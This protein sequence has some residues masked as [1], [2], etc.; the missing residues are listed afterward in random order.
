MWFFGVATLSIRSLG[1]W[2]VAERYIRQTLPAE[3]IWKRRFVILEQRLGILQPVRL[4]VTARAQVPAVVGWLRPI[5]LMPAS[6]LIGLTPEQ[7]EALLAHE[8]AHVRRHDFLVNLLQTAAETLF[9]Y[10]PAVWWL[11]RVIRNE[12]ENCCDDLAVQACGNVLTYARA[13]AEVE[14]LLG[15]APSLA[16]A[17]GGGSLLARIQRLLGKNAG[18]Q[19]VSSTSF[20]LVLTIAVFAMFLMNIAGAGLAQHSQLPAPQRPADSTVTAT[21]PVKEQT[22]S[23]S[24]LDEIEAAGFRNLDI[25]ELI[26]LKTHRID[27][28]YIRQ[29]RAAGYNLSPD[30]LVRFRSH[31]IDEEFIQEMKGVGLEGLSADDLIRLRSHG[32]N[33][34][35]IKEVQ[36]LGFPQMSVDEVI[37]LR[38]HGI[39]PDYIREAQKRFKAITLEQLI[40]LRSHGIL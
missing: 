6:V 3:D 30:D 25:D 8:L 33:G 7:V 23:G 29:T 26:R 21:T 11:N 32:A 5:V 22:S 28:D 17:A 10:H 14:R 39:D 1:G 35:W 31:G 40:V 38:S 15:P 12:R 37:R 27:A 18:T 36:S 24:W 13:L 20:L 2:I 19:S 16:M 4:A 34:V 9:F